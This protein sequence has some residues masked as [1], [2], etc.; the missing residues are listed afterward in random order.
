[1]KHYPHKPQIKTEDILNL[2]NQGL[3]CGQIA[4]NIDM[5]RM[6]VRKRLNKIGIRPRPSSAYTGDKRYWRWKGESSELERKRFSRFHQVWSKSVRDRDENIC[7]DC[8]IEEKR[9]HAHH[10]VPLEECLNSCL[11]F[12]INNGVTLCPKCHKHRHKEQRTYKNG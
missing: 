1:M 3:S 8:G 11:E 6:S 5:N 10:I 4:I 7:Q 2:Y 9:M 12:D